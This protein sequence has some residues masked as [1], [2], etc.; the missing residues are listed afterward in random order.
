MNNIVFKLWNIKKILKIKK[1]LVI[2]IF[3]EIEK[4]ICIYI[5]LNI[6]IYIMFFPKKLCFLVVLYFLNLFSRLIW[7][8]ENIDFICLLNFEI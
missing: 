1:Y 2:L 4:N 8:Y 7:N 6:Y 5:V 3:Y